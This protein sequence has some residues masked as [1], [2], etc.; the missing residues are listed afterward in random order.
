MQL[1]AHH[2]LATDNPAAE[3]SLSINSLTPSARHDSYRTEQASLHSARRDLH[4]RARTRSRIRAVSVRCSSR[5]H[6]RNQQS[7]SPPTGRREL[8]AVCALQ[9]ACS[10][11]SRQPT[12]GGPKQGFECTG[13]RAAWLHKMEPIALFHPHTFC[14][15]PWHAL[16][17]TICQTFRAP[18]ALAGADDCFGCPTVARRAGSRG[19]CYLRV[20]VRLASRPDVDALSPGDLCPARWLGRRG[21]IAR[22]GDGREAARVGRRRRCHAARRAPYPSWFNEAS[23]IAATQRTTSL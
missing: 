19:D 13:K 22:C 4:P 23:G 5:S 11:Q 8:A 2:T 6:P 10:Y 21:P 7:R 15:S 9:A 14:E 16:P 3:T 12:S 17:N 1:S 20:G 18:V